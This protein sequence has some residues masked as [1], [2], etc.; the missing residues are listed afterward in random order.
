MEKI[1]YTKMDSGLSLAAG[2]RSGRLQANSD[3][4]TDSNANTA[5]N[6]NP[7]TANSDPAATSTRSTGDGSG[8]P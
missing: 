2:D 6:G 3:T 8:R 1:G 7:R 5:A 4:T